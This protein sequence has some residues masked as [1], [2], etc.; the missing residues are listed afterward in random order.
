MHACTCVCSKYACMYVRVFIWLSQLASGLEELEFE[1][2]NLVCPI[3][4]LKIASPVTIPGSSEVFDKTSVLE[5]IEGQ[6]ACLG[7]QQEYIHAHVAPSVELLFESLFTI[8][9]MYIVYHL[10]AY[11]TVFCE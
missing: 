7:E 3:S 10:H 5:R 9:Y 11:V 8:T 6:L 4:H 2:I 1:N